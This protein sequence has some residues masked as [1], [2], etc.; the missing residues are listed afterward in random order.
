MLKTIEKMNVKLR[1]TAQ[2]KD[3]A[4]LETENIEL[5]PN[6]NLHDLLKKLASRYG[7][8]FGNILFDENGTYRNSNLIAI[9]LFQ[10]SYEENNELKDGDEIT[11]ISPVSGG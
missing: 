6:E 8:E 3:K 5:K 4:G 2:L 7:E 9:Y 10:V 1:Y 11:L